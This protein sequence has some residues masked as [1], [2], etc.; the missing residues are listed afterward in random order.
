MQEEDLAAGGAKELDPWQKMM[1]M[2]LRQLLAED[3]DEGDGSS[4]R[5]AVM[6]ILSTVKQ[7]GDVL[8]RR[9]P[10]SCPPYVPRL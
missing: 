3:A 6:K 2:A 1:A 5:P 4:S 10:P 9:R 8:V 7:S